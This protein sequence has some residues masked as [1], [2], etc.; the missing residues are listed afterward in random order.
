MMLMQSFL[1][2][3]P[4]AVFSDSDATVFSGKAFQFSPVS[5]QLYTFS[6]LKLIA[7]IVAINS[8]L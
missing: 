1:V 2:L 8:F 4:G 5:S 3:K 6:L 7:D